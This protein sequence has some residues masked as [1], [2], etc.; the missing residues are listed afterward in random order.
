MKNAKTLK[1][2]IS[3]CGTDLVVNFGGVE[4]PCR[5]I[6]NPLRYKNK[7]YLDS[8]MS[9]FGAI[10]RTRILYIGPPDPDFTKDWSNTIISSGN[11]KYSVTRADMISL[12]DTPLYIWAVLG[13]VVEG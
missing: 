3:R 7:M 12:G 4:I 2:M 5:A 8:D 11:Q 9:D 6:I 1:T 13:N 10:D